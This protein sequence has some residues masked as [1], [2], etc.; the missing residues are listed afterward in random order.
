[1]YLLMWTL[2]LL[3]CEVGDL[4]AQGSLPYCWVHTVRLYSWSTI[5]DQL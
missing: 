5:V 1:M 2:L 4:L 3:V